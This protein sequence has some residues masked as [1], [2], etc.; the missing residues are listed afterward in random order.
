MRAPGLAQRVPGLGL[1]DCGY[2]YQEPVSGWSMEMCSCG[3]GAVA[4]CILCDRP[5]CDLHVVW[6]DGQVLCTDHAAIVDDAAATR[7]LQAALDG[8]AA[9]VS[10]R[11]DPDERALLLFLGRDGL[12]AGTTGLVEQ[13]P[14]GASVDPLA[15]DW[16][17]WGRRMVRDMLFTLLPEATAAFKYSAESNW[18]ELTSGSAFAAWAFAH[19]NAPRLTRLPVVRR[20]GHAELLSLPLRHVPGLLIAGASYEAPTG[21]VPDGSYTPP[22]YLLESGAVV[23]L[24]NGYLQRGDVP[25]TPSPGEYGKV[26][27]TLQLHG[28][29]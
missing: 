14:P 22:R 24:R 4:G 9:R 5:L 26:V 20:I 11:I 10:A 12:P 19:P 2:Q 28:S 3:M 18:L 13:R 21:D 17:V 1:R 6:R 8:V 29:S 25:T 7:R 15:H 27:A 23:T 16:R